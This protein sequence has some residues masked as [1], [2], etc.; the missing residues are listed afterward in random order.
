MTGDRKRQREA[1]LN[2]FWK[3]VVGAWISFST[4]FRTEDNLLC[5]ENVFNSDVTKFKENKYRSWGRKGVKFIGDLYENGKLMKWERFGDVYNIKCVLLEH[6][7]LVHSLPTSIKKE[8]PQGWDQRPPFPARIQ[9]LLKHNTFTRCFT[10][11]Q[12]EHNSS[13]HAD[14]T[15]I[16]GKWIR[17]IGNFE[18]LSVLCVQKASAATRYTS[19]QY[20]L[21][22]RIL[23][24]NVFLSIIRVQ[25]NDTCS[26]CEADPESLKHLFLTCPLVSK[27]WD[28]VSQ[29]MLRNNLGHLDNIIKI[30]GHKENEI[31]THCVTIAK[32]VIYEARRKKELPHF[33]QFKSWLLRD[34]IAEE[35]IAHKNGKMENFKRKWKS[36]NVSLRRNNSS[37][38]FVSPTA[39]CAVVTDMGAAARAS[40]ASLHRGGPRFRDQRGGEG[41]GRAAV[42]VRTAHAAR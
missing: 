20:K 4:E 13:A 18:A 3:D 12:A 23:T 15:R 7:G 9:Y 8:M 31:I 37:Q 32:Y 14:M 6:Q 27:F 33:L 21:V 5:Y 26:F 24:T 17:D 36:L 16:K 41:G 39:C 34:L 11:L 40:A 29:F 35:Y 1:I 38:S 28:D 25:E 22:M 19:F 42:L 2:P 10:K 30:F